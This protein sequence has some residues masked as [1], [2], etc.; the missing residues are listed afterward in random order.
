MDYKTA[1]VNV[2]ANATWVAKLQE[3]AGISND[4]AGKFPLRGATLVASADGVGSK[5]KLA[6]NLG[7][8]DTI[9][10]DLVAMNVN[11]IAA[12]H[13]IPLFFLDYIGVHS[14]D[15][16]ALQE[17]M[18]GIIEG[19]SQAGCKLLGGETAE[20]PITYP[21]DDASLAGFAVGLVTP[22][23]EEDAKEGDLIIGYPSSGLHSNGFTLIHQLI[24]DK[25]LTLSDD[26]LDP[27]IIYSDI[28]RHAHIFIKKAAHITG[29]GLKENI[30]R[31]LDGAVIY[32]SQWKESR[33]SIF[34]VLEHILPE[35][36]LYK[37]FNMGIGFVVIIEKMNKDTIFKLTSQFNPIVIGEVRGNSIYIFGE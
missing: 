24:K 21:P 7:K 34:D 8:L 33:A 22:T 5:T 36:E 29:G 16:D 25:S 32:P 13:A 17:I 14:I 9:G 37:T 15:Q 4:F 12:S 11:D 23:Q 6:Y 30:S 2:E 10:I 35:E 20:I 31:V 18:T 26:L 27:T 28:I 19:C 1:G 3:M